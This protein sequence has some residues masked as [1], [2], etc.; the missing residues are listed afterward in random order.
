ME[1]PIRWASGLIWPP[2]HTRAKHHVTYSHALKTILQQEQRNYEADVLSLGPNEVVLPVGVSQAFNVV[3]NVAATA[4]QNAAE[5]A[6]QIN[7]LCDRKTI[8]LAAQFVI[9][10]SA[11]RIIDNMSTGRTTANLQ[12]A[13]RQVQTEFP[14]SWS[15]YV[16]GASMSESAVREMFT[17]RFLVRDTEV[18][19]YSTDAHIQHDSSGNEYRVYEFQNSLLGWA[20]V[21]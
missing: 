7:A 8:A 12:S 16:G 18:R 11:A 20:R 14:A 21:S 3:S 15:I 9:E 1:Y 17:S 13:Y 4:G 10:R 19:K 2:S 5:A 6:R